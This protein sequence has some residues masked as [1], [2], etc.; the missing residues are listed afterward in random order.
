MEQITNWFKNSKD[1]YEGVAIYASIKKTRTLRTLN[2]GKSRRTMSL[3]VAE[4]RK[5]KNGT[6]KPKPVPKTIV[7]EL[8]KAP[9]TQETI[10]VEVERTVTTQQSVQK[11]FTGLRIGDLPAELRPRYSRARTIFIEMIELKFALNDLPPEAEE[12]ALKIML[13]IDALDEERDLIWK[14]LH[15]WNQ[16]KTILPSKNIDFSKMDRYELDKE[17]RNL[18]SYITKKHQRIDKWYEDLASEESKHKQL[19]IENKINKA[20]TSIH[21][22]NINI[23]KI[24]K[25]L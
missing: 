15:H 7:S 10:N 23:N 3:L 8:L 2:K 14:E 20:E 9:P 24:D 11:E 12:S 1:Y 22:M 6:T 4:L 25:L 13:Q 21:Q 19:L 16:F 18:K 17:R 5:Y